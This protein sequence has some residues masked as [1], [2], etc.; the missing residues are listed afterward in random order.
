M[1]SQ[2]WSLIPFELLSQS[3]RQGIFMINNNLFLPC[4]EAVKVKLQ[5]DFFFCFWSGDD[6]AFSLGANM[7][8]VPFPIIRTLI[9]FKKSA[10]SWCNPLP[11]SS[12]QNKIV[13]RIRSQHTSF[14]VQLLS[15]HRVWLKLYHTWKTTPGLSVSSADVFI[16]ELSLSYNLDFKPHWFIC[17]IR[18]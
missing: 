11:E 14:G 9:P 16:A 5:I 17:E 13:W 12:C 3:N 18:K 8:G 4:L 2:I 10:P 15:D 1:D 6:P 7:A